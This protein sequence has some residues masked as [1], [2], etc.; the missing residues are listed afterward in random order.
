MWRLEHSG[1]WARRVDATITLHPIQE[2]QIEKPQEYEIFELNEHGE[3][4]QPPDR[5]AAR[6]LA[7]QQRQE[8]NRSRTARL[9]RLISSLPIRLMML[10]DNGATK[11]EAMNWLKD[12]INT[13]V[14]PGSV[15]RIPCLTC[16]AK[17]VWHNG[18]E[19]L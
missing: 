13:F 15:Q 11:R 6:A 17:P 14:K 12:Y 18:G 9:V 1:D 10:D 16:S 19:S 2:L 5:T 8:Q 3:R 4:V 7:Q